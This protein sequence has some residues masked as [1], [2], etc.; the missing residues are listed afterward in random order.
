MQKKKP[1]Y[2]EQKMKLHNCKALRFN[3]NDCFSDGI[4]KS[5]TQQSRR[6]LVT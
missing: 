6:D 2:S 1:T 5:T 4:K 3:F